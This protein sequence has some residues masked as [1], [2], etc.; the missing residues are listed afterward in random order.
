MSKLQKI[1]TH[2]ELVKKVERWKRRGGG[3]FTTELLKL[4]YEHYVES[5]GFFERIDYNRIYLS[6]CLELYMVYKEENESIDLVQL[7]RERTEEDRYDLPILFHTVLH[8]FDFK[9]FCKVNT[10]EYIYN[11]N[12]MIYFLGHFHCDSKR[13]REFDEFFFKE[14]REFFIKCLSSR[15]FMDILYSDCKTT[16]NRTMNSINEV[17]LINHNII[18]YHDQLMAFFESEYMQA[19]IGREMAM[20][21]DEYTHYKEFLQSVLE[22][23]NVDDFTIY[24]DGE[25]TYL[26]NKSLYE[27]CR[28]YIIK[29]QP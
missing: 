19:K 21:I 28:I 27:I 29:N 20:G 24:M 9:N 14:Y 16:M 4:L 22:Q 7:L 8:N 5:D 23:R 1:V 15:K 17:I 11:V 3:D 10:L 26:A 18:K 2:K 13:T 12:D 6:M 25:W